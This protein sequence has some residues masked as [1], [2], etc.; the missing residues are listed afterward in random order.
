[1]IQQLSNIQSKKSPFNET[2]LTLGKIKIRLFFF[3]GLETFNSF[4]ANKS[5]I[6]LEVYI[7]KKNAH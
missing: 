2:L 5:K 4:Q 1:M 7:K 6:Q 3:Y